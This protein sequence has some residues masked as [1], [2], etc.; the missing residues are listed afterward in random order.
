MTGH[1][2]I[3]SEWSTTPTDLAGWAMR[4]EKMRARAEAAEDEVDIL[5][6]GLKQLAYPNYDAKATGL[7]AREMAAFARN[8]LRE[9]DADG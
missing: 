8:L 9:I 1:A 3:L 6:E 2:E 5:I 7:D 4:A